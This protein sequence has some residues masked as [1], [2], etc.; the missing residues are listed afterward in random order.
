MGFFVAGITE[1]RAE[2]ICVMYWEEVT[3]INTRTDL[4]FHLSPVIHL[5]TKIQQALSEL[6]SSLQYMVQSKVLS[7]N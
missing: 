1:N 5:S 6:F 2:E 4:D 3:P 7:V